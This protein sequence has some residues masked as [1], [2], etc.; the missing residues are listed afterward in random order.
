MQHH[1]RKPPPPPPPPFA[2]EIALKRFG[3]EALEIVKAYGAEADTQRGTF[4][5][6]LY[7]DLFAVLTLAPTL[8]LALKNPWNNGNCGKIARA[9]VDSLASKLIVSGLPAAAEA[10]LV[11]DQMTSQSEWNRKLAELEPRL[12]AEY[13][14]PRGESFATTVTLNLTGSIALAVNLQLAL[15]HPEVD[16]ERAA[17]A[18]ETIDDITQSLTEAGLPRALALLDLGQRAAA[19]QALLHAAKMM[20]L[21]KL[22]DLLINPLGASIGA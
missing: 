11:R 4:H 8:D 15:S 10:L 9:V 12:K 20:I 19:D 1:L 18:R 7:C 6:L 22:L 14:S 21:M 3:Q 2:P 17:V 13:Q 16:Q 5:M